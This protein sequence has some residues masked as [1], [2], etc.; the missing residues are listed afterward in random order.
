MLGIGGRFAGAKGMVQMPNLANLSPTAATAA[1][2]A[3]GLQLGTASEVESSNSGDNEKVF[4]QSAVAGSL[5]DYDSVINYSYYRYVPPAVVYTLDTVKI[6]DG[7]PSVETGCNKTP[8][9]QNASNQYYY[10]TRTL[11]PYK[12]K[13][14]ANGIW[15]GVSYGGYFTEYSTWDCSLT[16]NQCGNNQVSVTEISRSSC[17][18][19]E[20]STGYQNVTYRRN[21][22]SGSPS[23]ITYTEQQYGCTVPVSRYEITR[24]TSRGPCSSSGVGGCTCGQRTVTTT[25]IYNTGP[26]DTITSTECCPNSSTL[27]RTANFYD[28]CNNSTS[29]RPCSYREYYVDCLGNEIPG[30]ST[31]YS[32][33]AIACGCSSTAG[34][35]SCTSWSGIAS[36]GTYAATR[37]CTYRRPDCTTYTVTETQ[38]G[39]CTAWVGSGRCTSGRLSQTRTCYRS[40]CSTYTES[41]TV[42]C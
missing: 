30:T 29:T 3:A 25:I 38:C 35:V 7:S 34:L 31:R 39:G 41:R 42:S 16:A 21:Y 5:V 33:T 11:T 2:S 20:G 12:Y 14:L 6:A 32:C 13:L 9:L 36:S 18:G 26:N 10:C 4:S 27:V 19:P 24:S 1:L 22:V 17:I 8:N 40:D 15:D 28:S 37:T 23:N